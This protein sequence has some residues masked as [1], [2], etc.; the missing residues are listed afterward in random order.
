VNLKAAFFYEAREPRKASPGIGGG[1]FAK[2]NMEEKVIGV[3]LSLSKTWTRKPPASS[4]K[5]RS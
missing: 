5:P 2:D 3:G 4:D 1:K